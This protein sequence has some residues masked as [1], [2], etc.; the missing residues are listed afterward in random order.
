MI[1]EPFF[2]S[3]FFLACKYLFFDGWVGESWGF[4]FGDS[5]HKAI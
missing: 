1:I 3:F 5:N 2:Y 4:W